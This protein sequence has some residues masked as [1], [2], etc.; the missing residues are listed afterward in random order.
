MLAA[1][2]WPV[3][4]RLR[5]IMRASAPARNPARLAR[6][7]IAGSTGFPGGSALRA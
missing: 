1:F 6:F 2:D 7:A 3:Y 5:R 4:S